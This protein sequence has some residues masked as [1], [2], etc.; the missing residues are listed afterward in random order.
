METLQHDPSIDSGEDAETP[1][2]DTPVE[3]DYDV[4]LPETYNQN[5]NGVATG[6]PDPDA[7]SEPAVATA[8]QFGTGEHPLTDEQTPPQ[9]QTAPTLEPAAGPAPAE[10]QPAAPRGLAGLVRKSI[11]HDAA[12]PS[13][14]EENRSPAVQFDFGMENEPEPQEAPTT[15]PD[16]QGKR[17]TLQSLLKPTHPDPVH[18]PTE[19]AGATGALAAPASAAPPSPPPPPPPAPAPAAAAS[20][21][22]PSDIA[23]LVEDAQRHTLGNLSGIINELE[24]AMKTLQEAGVE[25]MQSGNFESVQLVM[26]NTKRLKTTKDRLA[27]LIDE[28]SNV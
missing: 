6:E 12:P 26:E 5:E 22:D 9:P 18:S 14:R 24:R 16:A 2:S 7:L 11:L 13:P 15:L 19:P 21:A 1:P 28:I 4:E 17:P 25:A 23:R 10:T 20:S 27:Q 8:D 3:Q